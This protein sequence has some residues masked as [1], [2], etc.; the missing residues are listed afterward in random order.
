[1]SVTCRLVLVC[2]VDVAQVPE[3]TDGEWRAGPFVETYTDHMDREVTTDAATRATN[4]PVSLAGRL[5]G[6]TNASS[7]QVRFSTDSLNVSWNIDVQPILSGQASLRHAELLLSEPSPLGQDS[8]RPG[9]LAL[10][11]EVTAPSFADAVQVTNLLARQRGGIGASPIHGALTYERLRRVHPEL[12]RGLVFPTDG[13]FGAETES[14]IFSMILI[15]QMTVE[16]ADPGMLSIKQAYSA[17]SCQDIERLHA[18]GE[19]LD[20]ASK[21]VLQIS[22]SWSALFLRHGASFV[23]HTHAQDP[24]RGFMPIYFGTL[25][26]DALM[27]VRLQLLIVRQV[28]SAAESLLERAAANPHLGSVSE[29]FE[30]LDRQLAINSARYW[31]R[32][33]ESNAGNSIK[34][35]HAIQDAMSFPLRLGALD[36]HIDGLARISDADANKQSLEAQKKLTKI[37]TLLGS[38]AIPVTF[39]TDLFQVLGLPATLLSICGLAVSIFLLGGITWWGLRRNL[40]RS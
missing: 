10:H 32:R 24:F 23:V 20:R 29:D 1:L 33:S 14:T 38:I 6:K 36:A 16:D 19:A 26:T 34:I 3:N 31:M 27:L 4:F 18:S 9:I 39:A 22:K 35:I 40:S 12:C 15:D 11:L 13:E 2:D 37:V 25:Y 8:N 21:S 7:D 5:F 17:A 30:N 28:E